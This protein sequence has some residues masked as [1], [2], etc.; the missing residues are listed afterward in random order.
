MPH[1]ITII[2]DA[3]GRLDALVV[4]EHGDAGAQVVFDDERGTRR[5]TFITYS[6][7]D[8]A[9]VPGYGRVKMASYR[10]DHETF[11]AKATRPVVSS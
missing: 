11:S 7:E 2:L 4:P 1:W 8:D 9:P 10:F 6:R 5:E 3:D